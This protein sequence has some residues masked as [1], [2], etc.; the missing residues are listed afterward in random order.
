MSSFQRE[1]REPLKAEVK[2]KKQERRLKSHACVTA[3]ENK[4]LTDC[5]TLADA[6]QVNN[7]KTHS[8]L[9]STVT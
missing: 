6:Q 4:K 9:Y 3:L 1:Q 7:K 5:P 2:K 8:L